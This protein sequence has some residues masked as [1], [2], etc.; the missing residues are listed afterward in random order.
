MS[1]SGRVKRK[2]KSIAYKNKTRNIPKVEYRNQEKVPLVTLYTSVVLG[3]SL[4]ELAVM[5]GVMNQF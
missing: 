1:R 4:I 5:F 2:I 3:T